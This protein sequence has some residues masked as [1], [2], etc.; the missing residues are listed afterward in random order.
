[1]KKDF[2]TSC[3]T[4]R[5]YLNEAEAVAPGWDVY[6]CLFCGQWHRATPTSI[7]MKLSKSLRQKHYERRLHHRTHQ[8]RTA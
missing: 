1:V 7:K 2:I 5:A 4:K 6:L 8:L 3:F